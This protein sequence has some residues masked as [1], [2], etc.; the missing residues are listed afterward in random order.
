MKL[1][2]I[3]GQYGG[4]TIDAPSG[5]KTHPMSE[6][7]RGAIFNMLGDITGLS[8]LDAYSGSASLALEAV[9]RGATDVVAI[10]SDKNAYMT[11]QANI[12]V[13]K[14]QN[15]KVTRANI[16]SWLDNNPDK[17]FNLILCDPPYD[18]VK[19]DILTRI[20]EFLDTNG[21]IVYSLPPANSVQMPDTKHVCIAEKIYGDAKIVIYQV[22]G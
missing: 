19:S 6:K 8:V 5:H 14:A 1:R 21:I 2:I 13:L 16:R 12:K 18:D 11:I 10:D 4:R 3:S 9:S 17:R 15:I 7:I 20:A 22:K